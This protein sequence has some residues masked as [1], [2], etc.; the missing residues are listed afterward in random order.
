MEKFW[1]WTETNRL[2]SR[3]PQRPL[4]GIKGLLIAGQFHEGHTGIMM[5]HGGI[6]KGAGLVDV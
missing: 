6:G 5:G 1:S 2:F 3:K 4:T